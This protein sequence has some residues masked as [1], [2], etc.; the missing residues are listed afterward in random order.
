MGLRLLGEVV[1]SVKGLDIRGWLRKVEASDT[2][3]ALTVQQNSVGS[4]VE[5][6]ISGAASTMGLVVRGAS[7]QTASLAEFRD[8]VE[9]ARIKVTPSGIVELYRS[10]GVQIGEINATSNPATYRSRGAGVDVLITTD[11]GTIRHDR[12]TR[13]ESD[14]AA[15]VP[16]HVRGAASQSGD[17]QQW[18]NS[19]DAVLANVLASG[20][21]VSTVALRTKHEG[22]ATPTGGASGDIRVGNGKIWVNDAG[23]WKS[24]AVA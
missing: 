11:S 2:D 3:P 15:T 22:A 19:A 13:I 17:L 10:D 7:G 8:S 5:K 4:V 16:L 9:V 1:D 14:A 24:V 6:L 20:E 18:T 21:L 12:R 23:T